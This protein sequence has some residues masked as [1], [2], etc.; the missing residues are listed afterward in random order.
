MSDTT[1]IDD[2][3]DSH[4][5]SMRDEDL[6]YD[7]YH[8]MIQDLEQTGGCKGAYRSR[9]EARQQ[10]RNHWCCCINCRNPRHRGC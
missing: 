7:A 10:G 8:Q 9:E 2:I 4:L 1:T 3:I 6:S 5:A